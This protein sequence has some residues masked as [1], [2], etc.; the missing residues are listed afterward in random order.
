MTDLERCADC[1]LQMLNKRHWDIA[2][3]GRR[4]EMKRDGFRRGHGHGLCSAC[5]KRMRRRGGVMPRT[6]QGVPAEVVA[7]EWAWIANPWRTD[8]SNAAE[9][10]PRLGMS[11]GALLQSV[12]RLRAEGALD[13][14]KEWVA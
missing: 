13:Q 5:W 11:P 3:P 9:L 4:R 10:A 12:A 14:P 6:M 7:E 2:T 1:G 8:E